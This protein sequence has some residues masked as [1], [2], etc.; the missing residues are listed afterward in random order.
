MSCWSGPQ[1]KANPIQELMTLHCISVHERLEDTISPPDLQSSDVFPAPNLASTGNP[2]AESKG[3]MDGRYLG[4]RESKAVVDPHTKTPLL[5]LKAKR[6]K[7]RSVG[8][9]T[10]PSIYR[11]IKILDQ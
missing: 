5:S 8:L 9:R 6:H 3:R 4:A 11:E 7:E 2:E 1:D 10:N